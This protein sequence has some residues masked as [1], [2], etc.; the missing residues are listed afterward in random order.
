MITG[1]RA[2]LDTLLSN[3]NSSTLAA[4]GLVPRLA[5]NASQYRSLPVEKIPVPLWPK[6][7]VRHEQRNSQEVNSPLPLCIHCLESIIN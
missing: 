6:T 4:C 2:P 7:N 1:L 3:F 5:S